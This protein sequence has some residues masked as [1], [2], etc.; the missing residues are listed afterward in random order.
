MRCSSHAALLLALALGGCAAA[1]QLPP[2][3]VR[4]RGSSAPELW[5]VQAGDVLQGV[6]GD[7]RGQPLVGAHVRMR[8]LGADS[9]A[10]RLGETGRHG[11]FG[12]DSVP[13]GRYL[14]RAYARSHGV[15]VDTVEL[16][17]DRGTVPRIQLCTRTSPFDETSRRW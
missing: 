13:P 17:Y 1:G 7:V 11:A 5:T 9:T 6:V 14:A 8:P 4:C 2:G 10:E 3:S 16:A 12:I 15:W